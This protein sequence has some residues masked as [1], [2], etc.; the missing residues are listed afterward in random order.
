MD[1]LLQDLLELQLSDGVKDG[2]VGKFHWPGV[3]IMIVLNKSR[4]SKEMGEDE[5]NRRRSS[6]RVGNL[7]GQSSMQWSSSKRWPLSHSSRK[8]CLGMICNSIIRQGCQWPQQL[9]QQY[10]EDK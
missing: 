8:S 1:G 3:S 7:E 4:R 6:N 9:G 2:Q 5:N 10:K